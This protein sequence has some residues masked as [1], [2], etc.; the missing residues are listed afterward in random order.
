M[1]PTRSEYRKFSELIGCM[2]RKLSLL[3]RDQKI[4]C[5]TTMS[6]CYTIETLAQNGSLSM[7]QLS[8][9]MGVTVSTMTRVVDILV[10]DEV[11]SRRG[12]PKDRRQVC[13][14]LT[15]K[16]KNLA[17]RL[18]DCADEYSRQILNV[19]SAEQRAE[20]VK[21]LELLVDA[22]DGVRDDKCKCFY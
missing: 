16:G 17:K 13:I 5:G 15:A 2:I 1:G 22:V 9:Q 8:K 21:S 18:Q 3:E 19:I 6:Q 10:R 7:N 12:N 11:V 20:V 14:E 4:C